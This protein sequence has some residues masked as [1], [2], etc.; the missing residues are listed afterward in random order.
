MCSRK[1]IN[2]IVI[3][4]LILRVR[5]DLFVLQNLITAD[6]GSSRDLD[7][8]KK[9]VRS[10]ECNLNIVISTNILQFFSVSF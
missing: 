1:I 2:R 5:Q 6:R 9:I 3:S 4:L 8:Q 7:F 10:T